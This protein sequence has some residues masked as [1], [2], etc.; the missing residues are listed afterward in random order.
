MTVLPRALATP[1]P[2]PLTP[3]EI[4]RPVALVRVP[5]DGV[6]KAPPL[7]TTDPAVPTLTPKAVATPVPGVVVAS[8][9][10]EVPLVFVT[11]SE[12]VPVFS[13]ASPPIVTPDT[14][15]PV[16]AYTAA[17][18]AVPDVTVPLPLEI[19]LQPNPVPVVQVRALDADEQEGSE[20]P[21]GV[22]AV[23]APR[24]VLAD[25]AGRS[26]NTIDLNDGAAAAPVVGPAKTVF[27]LC[28]FSPI[29]KVPVDVMGEPEM[30]RKDGTVAATLVTVPPPALPLTLVYVIAALS[31]VPTLKPALV[32]FHVIV[33]PETLNTGKAS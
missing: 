28:V 6:P 15:V 7:T 19:V 20:R 3:V 12:P 13:V 5:E 26:A 4:G 1:V 27:A 30:L 11:V 29:A 24:T 14:V 8:A 9:L 25:K 17:C 33:V 32:E 10:N 31:L 16:E 2:S 18:P 21:E 22:V 23:K